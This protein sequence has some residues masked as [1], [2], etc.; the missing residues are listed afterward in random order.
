MRMALAEALMN[1]ISAP[2]KNL[3]LVR[4]SA[5]WMAACGDEEEDYALREGVQA[6]SDICIEL[7]I[8]IPVGKDSLSMRTKWKEDDQELQVKAPCQASSQPWLQL[9]TYH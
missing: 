4:L 8:A 3:D 9:K 1:L 6:L 2:V 7:G 5:N